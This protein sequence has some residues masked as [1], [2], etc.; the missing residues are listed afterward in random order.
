LSTVA[1]LFFIQRALHD[2]AT[3]DAAAASR[4]FVPSAVKVYGVRMPII[5][6]LAREHKAGGL[7]LS[8][9]LWRS[10][11]FEER[12]LAAKVLGAV[13]GKDPDQTLALIEEFSREVEDWA[14][15]DTLGMQ[16]VK[17]IAAKQ[18]ARVLEMSRRLIAA[19]AMWQ[20]RLGVV[21]LTHYAK[22]AALR[23]ELLAIVRPLRAEKEHYIQKAL[24]W[25]DRDL[26]AKPSSR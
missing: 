17:A 23:D 9:A 24:A 10:G 16:S 1:P 22:D 4:K 26:D 8:K 3:A 18:Q 15:C 14:V 25:L 13:A 21:L 20:R 11:A 7:A 19:H 6:G 5:N 2:A 12:L